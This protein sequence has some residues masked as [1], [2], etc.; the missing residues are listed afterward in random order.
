[1]QI[2]QDVSSS[3]V[4]GISS[5]ASSLCFQFLRAFI[6]P[7]EKGHHYVMPSQG[8]PEPSEDMQVKPLCPKARDTDFF[9]FL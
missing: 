4:K 6:V 1:Q 8:S 7:I 2:S 5:T 9:T 3:Y